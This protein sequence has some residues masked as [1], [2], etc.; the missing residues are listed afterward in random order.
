MSWK[1]LIFALFHVLFTMFSIPVLTIFCLIPAYMYS[2]NGTVEDANM[3][4][5]AILSTINTYIQV[6]KDALTF[7]PAWWRLK[8]S[9]F[10]TIMISRYI[11]SLFK[12]T[13]KNLVLPA[14][15]TSL[16]PLTPLIKV[17]AYSG[18]IMLGVFGE[19]VE[20]LLYF[21]I[22]MKFYKAE[23]K[24]PR[25]ITILRI[26]AHHNFT[27]PL[28]RRYMVL[29]GVQLLQSFVGWWVKIT[30]P[31][32]TFFDKMHAVGL[33][34]TLLVTILLTQCVITT[35]GTIDS[36]RRMISR[37]CIKVADPKVINTKS[38]DTAHLITGTSVDTLILE[39]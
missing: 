4:N 11:Y 12:Y 36:A 39:S 19:L 34:K 3:N 15:G 25:S 5:T 38:H 22:R 33:H 35:T 2:L 8:I 18:G 9:V 17:M 1:A 29:S 20:E 10:H 14:M 6:R 24:P 7:H 28:P 37:Q 31:I 13:G 23:I 16:V 21:N 27:P 30:K 32:F 26:C